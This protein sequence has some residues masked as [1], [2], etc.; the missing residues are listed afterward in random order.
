MLLK[1][2]NKNFFLDIT[3]RPD[4]AFG[5]GNGLV[6]IINVT[7]EI[8]IKAKFQFSRGYNKK[9]NLIIELDNHK[10][11]TFSD[12]NDII[13]FFGKSWIYLYFKGTY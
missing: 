11:V 7:D 10:N 12:E 5:L 3:K 4:V 8:L 1:Q 13:F 6:Y 9:I 2:N